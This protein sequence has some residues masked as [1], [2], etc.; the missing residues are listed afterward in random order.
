MMKRP[1]NEEADW[2]LMVDQLPVRRKFSEAPVSSPA[3]VLSPW[4]LRT[5]LAAAD[6][7]MVPPAP[8]ERPKLLIRPKN[9]VPPLRSSVAPFST[10]IV[11]P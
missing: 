9:C 10:L 4:L 8:E 3:K 7:V 5:R 2:K 11:L 6:E 1:P